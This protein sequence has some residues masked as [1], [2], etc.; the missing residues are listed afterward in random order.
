MFFFFL[1]FHREKCQK[2]IKET[3]PHSA[4][5]CAHFSVAPLAQIVVFTGTRRR[6][7]LLAARDN[8]L[9]GSMFIYNHRC[10]STS[11]TSG[12]NTSEVVCILAPDRAD[13]EGVLLMRI[14][15][16]ITTVYTEDVCWR[17]SFDPSR[18]RWTHHTSFSVWS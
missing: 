12:V 4:T 7:S 17:S 18:R 9:E 2:G 13:Q 16:L 3:K 1:Y 10:G 6:R 15:A 8:G 14:E 5:I 11:S